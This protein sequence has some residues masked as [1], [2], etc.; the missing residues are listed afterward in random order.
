MN[1][2]V[3]AIEIDWAIV[4][5]KVDRPQASDRVKSLIGIVHEFAVS[6]FP[7]RVKS[8]VLAVAVRSPSRTSF[9]MRVDVLDT[10][11]RVLLEPV[12]GTV[13]LRTSGEFTVDLAGFDILA[14]GPVIIRLSIDDAVVKEFRLPAGIVS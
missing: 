11:D 7:A 8:L 5:A 14:A 3:G 6:R 12:T 2:S 1:D 10:F 13:P 4:C 9:R